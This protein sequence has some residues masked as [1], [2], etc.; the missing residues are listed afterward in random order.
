MVIEDQAE[1]I[2]KLTPEQVAERERRPVPFHVLIN[3]K[4][5]LLGASVVKFFEGCLSVTG[6]SAI[7]PRAPRV[8]VEC[9]NHN[10]EPQVIEAAGWHARILQHEIDHLY[11]TLYVDRMLSRSLMTTDNLA[12]HWKDKTIAEVR[13]VLEC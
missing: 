12:R 13:R 9:L 10:A 5:T 4:L 2:Q 6:F 7:V 8:R 1:F 3:P 11:G